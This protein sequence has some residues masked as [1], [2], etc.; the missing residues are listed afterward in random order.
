VSILADT[1]SLVTEA[2]E[3]STRRITIATGRSLSHTYLPKMT[4]RLQNSLGKF[5]LRILTTST[6]G[7]IKM[8]ADSDVDFLVCYTHSTILD[9][10][11]P[12]QYQYKVIGE[13]RIIAVSIPIADGLPLYS[14]PNDRASV[15]TP[16]LSFNLNMSLGRVVQRII[17]K[18]RIS[19]HLQVVYESDMADSIYTMAIQGEGLAW[20]PESLVNRDLEHG[21]LVRADAPLNDAECQ[22][23][24]YRPLSSPKALIQ[25]VWKEIAKW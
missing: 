17:D 15:R 4:A 20:L 12:E 3:I 21:R 11:D 7:G 10:I 6:A 23:A 13:E 19:H 25:Q 5:N 22:I 18:N 9:K 1:R 24:I 14:V 16:L 2:S 8:L